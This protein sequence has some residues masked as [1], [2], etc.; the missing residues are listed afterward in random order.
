MKIKYTGIIL[1]PLMFLACSQEKAEDIVLQEFGPSEIVA[2]E[3]FNVQPDGSSAM[4]I[5]AK[6]A[7]PSTV[8]VIGDHEMPAAVYEDN[9]NV[10]TGVPP[11]LIS[12]PGTYS[13]YLLDKKTSKKSNELQFLVKGK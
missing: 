8:V 1:L 6:N 12:K 11:D 10:S 5:H 13:I 9:L 4:W 7:T 2:G 3:K